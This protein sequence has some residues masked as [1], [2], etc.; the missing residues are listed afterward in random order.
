MPP[1]NIQVQ[2]STFDQLD[3]ITLYQ[4]LRLRSEVFV[5]EQQCIYQ[6]LDNLD[7]KSQHL[8]IHKQSGLS[9]GCKLAP[10]LAY[11]RLLP[12]DL[13]YPEAAIGRI[14]TARQWRG[15]GYGRWLIN[16]AATCCQQ[17]YPGAPIKISAQL[18]LLALYNTCG[19]LQQGEPYDEDGIP[20]IA[21]RKI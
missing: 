4:I 3:A 20:H 10:L 16:Q 8:L 5:V 12:P 9:T 19:F 18:H 21:M 6:D 2:L 11:A 13:Q 17:S 7:Q 14:I 1:T 15:K